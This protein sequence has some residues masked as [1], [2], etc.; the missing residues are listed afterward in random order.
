M[1]PNYA[2]KKTLMETNQ[3]VFTCPVF[4]TKTKIAACFA[5]RELVWRGDKPEVRKGCQMCMRAGKCPINGILWDMIRTPDYDPYHSDVPKEGKLN[6]KHIAMIERT[7]VPEKMLE[8]ALDKG[9]I[10]DMEAK[11]MRASNN[12]ARKTASKG[13]RNPQEMSLVDVKVERKKGDKPAT[14]TLIDATILAASTG[15]MAAAVNNAMKESA[16]G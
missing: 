9:E 1:A 4:P 16:N 14:E 11:L 7:V 5:L 12:E 6:E 8:R 2:P 15:D 13:V 10:S 3:F